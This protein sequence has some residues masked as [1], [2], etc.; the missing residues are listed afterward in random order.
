MFSKVVRSYTRTVR[1]YLL[2]KI[3]KKTSESKKRRAHIK[4]NRKIGHGETCMK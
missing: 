1:K 3:E 2:L 4:R